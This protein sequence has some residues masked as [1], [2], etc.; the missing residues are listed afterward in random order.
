MKTKTKQSKVFDKGKFFFMFPMVDFSVHVP[1]VISP[2]MSG[3][4]IILE[5]FI[6]MK[7][8]IKLFE[9]VEDDMLQ[10]SNL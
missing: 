8:M 3:S 4:A 1:I 9:S 2:I 5:E 7:T 10:D 6:L